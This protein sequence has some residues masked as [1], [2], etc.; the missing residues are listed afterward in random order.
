MGVN[1]SQRNPKDKDKDK[2]SDNNHQSNYNSDDEAAIVQPQMRFKARTDLERIYESINR[3]SYGSANKSVLDRQLQNLGLGVAE[4]HKP[5]NNDEDENEDG[6][7]N[8][9]ESGSYVETTQPNKINESEITDKRTRR[10]K[11]T[12]INAEGRYIKKEDINYKTHFKGTSVISMNISKST[13]RMSNS[14]FNN[15]NN[16]NN[17]NN[18]IVKDE[19]KIFEKILEEALEENNNYEFPDVGDYK[20]NHNPH[21]SAREETNLAAL[22][23]L[24]DMSNNDVNMK[25]KF[26]TRKSMHIRSLEMDDQLFKKG[27][28][29]IDIIFKVIFIFK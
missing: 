25:N 14:N 10:K 6:F 21:K 13:K 22:G 28:I 15:A 18:D 4:E 5:K 27:N 20:M 7:G 17:A 8:N 29:E 1:T 23:I 26:G 24:R 9:L 2:D 19:N 16:A 3:N 11:I 12:D